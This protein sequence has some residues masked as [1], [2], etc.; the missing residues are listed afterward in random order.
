MQTAA[1]WTTSTAVS[2]WPLLFSPSIYKA[3]HRAARRLYVISR[4]RGRSVTPEAETSSPT[5]LPSIRPRVNH[6]PIPFAPSSY[7]YRSQATSPTVLPPL[8][9]SN[10]TPMDQETQMIQHDVSSLRTSS[11]AVNHTHRRG[12]SYD[13]GGP[14]PMDVDLS[15][16]TQSLD[17]K[18]HRYGNRDGEREREQNEERERD[19]SERDRQPSPPRSAH[20]RSSSTSVTPIQ[21]RQSPPVQTPGRLSQVQSWR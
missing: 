15:A 4:L 17:L 11:K 12:H 10:V 6:N 3:V 20:S 19:R 7:T 21:P 8:R 1:E 5:T 14:V 16:S 2:V 9:F 13:G 18:G